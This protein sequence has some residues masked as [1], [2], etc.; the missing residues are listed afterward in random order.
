MSVNVFNIFSVKIFKL[1]KITDIIDTICLRMMKQFFV[2]NY[3]FF[4]HLPTTVNI[5][6]GRIQLIYF[7][8]RRYN[9]NCTI[10]FDFLIS[11]SGK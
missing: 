3:A 2:E 6:R 4:I 5:V 9:N 7:Y 11:G 8:V 1:K 10:K